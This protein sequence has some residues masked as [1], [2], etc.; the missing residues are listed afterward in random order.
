MLW[1]LTLIWNVISELGASKKKKKVAIY[2]SYRIIKRKI[3]DQQKHRNEIYS[4]SP[5]G[6]I[7]TPCHSD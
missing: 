3:K 2:G 5:E 7:K 6:T 1:F 4:R